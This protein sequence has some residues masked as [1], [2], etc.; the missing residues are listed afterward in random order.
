MHDQDQPC[1]CDCGVFPRR[2]TRISPA[3]IRASRKSAWS[4][5]LYTEA[6]VETSPWTSCAPTGSCTSSPRPH[7]SAFVSAFEPDDSFEEDFRRPREFL[8]ECW[9]APGPCVV[10]H[11]GRTRKDPW[12]S[13][14]ENFLV[15]PALGVTGRVHPQVLFLVGSFFCGPGSIPHRVEWVRFIAS[16]LCLRP[17]WWVTFLRIT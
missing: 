7:F 17:D 6:V 16:S 2:E 9:N 4:L 13:R 3:S 8:C 12:S 1:P 14:A 10:R 5:T 11:F 15:T